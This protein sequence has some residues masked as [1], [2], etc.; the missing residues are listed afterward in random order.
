MIRDVLISMTM[1]V[2]FLFSLL[3]GMILAAALCTSL[4]ILY[5]ALSSPAAAAEQQLASPAAATPV[6]S[7]SDP[8][9]NSNPHRGGDVEISIV[10]SLT[11]STTSI[12]LLRRDAKT[13]DIF[14]L[15]FGKTSCWH[16]GRS[17]V[18]SSTTS[19]D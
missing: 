18:R 19:N 9:I 10:R 14:V 4:A 2:F 7:S 5:M 8:S 12:V 1:A 17:H 13:S 11:P 6:L 16:T 3:S 15:L